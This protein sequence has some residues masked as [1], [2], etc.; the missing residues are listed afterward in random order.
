M[1]PSLGIQLALDQLQ[2]A[3]DRLLRLP[4]RR[5]GFGG[6]GHLSRR[7]YFGTS[8]LLPWWADRADSAH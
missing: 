4:V 5:R 1:P 3:L 6:L 2:L 7:F 8:G